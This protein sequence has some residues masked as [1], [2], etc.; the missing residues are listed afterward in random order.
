MAVKRA[1]VRPIFLLS[2]PRSGSTLVQRILASHAA[3]ATKSEPWL[4]LPP[5][6]ALHPDMP[7]VSPWQRVITLGLQDLATA[8]PNGVEDYL[9]AANAFGSELYG[10]A[11]G[12][13][14]RYFLDKTPAYHWI[15]DDLF[16]TFCDAS[17]IYLWR[18]PLSVVASHVETF[19]Q[20]HW[21]VAKHA[22]DLFD[23]L[24]NLVCSYER[25]A[26]R[27][28][29][30]RFED[31]ATGSTPAWEKVFN[32]L[33]LEFDPQL[34]ERF[35]AVELNG[36]LGDVTGRAA[37]RRLD[38]EPL[39]KWKKTIT[40]PLRKAW[41]RRYI[42]WIGEERLAVMG[43]D[44]ATLEADL[45]SVQ[46]SMAE[47]PADARA[48]ASSMAREAVRTGTFRATGRGR[49]APSSWRRLLA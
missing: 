22:G 26:D 6:L 4:M 27:A 38:P 49:M 48:M 39:D 45:D 17:F 19:C 46:T 15:A 18:N 11:T 33:D 2:M 44:L 35:D 28:I 24:N 3:I 36:R 10:R 32:Y 31:L 40:T 5:L 16:R 20:G 13:G 25:N 30:A 14:E 8:L 42:R 7:F 43:Y 1:T 12:D 47:A 29:T 9:A 37:Y 21:G 41:C 34:L 23:G